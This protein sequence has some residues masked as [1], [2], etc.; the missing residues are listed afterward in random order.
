MLVELFA[1]DGWNDDDEDRRAGDLTGRL[2]GFEMAV[3]PAVGE[4]VEWEV[5]EGRGSGD[6]VWFLTARVRSRAFHFDE[7]NRQVTCRLTVDLC[8]DG[9]PDR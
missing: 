6:R 1:V 7:H 9:E 2:E 8:D 4:F 5:S 3:P